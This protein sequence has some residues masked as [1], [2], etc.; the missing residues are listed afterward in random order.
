MTDSPARPAP[1]YGAIAQIAVCSVIWGT[2]WYAITLQ[3]GTVD[4]LVSVTYRFALAAAALFA[5]CVL[6]RLPIRLTRAQHLAVALQGLL[7]FAVQYPLVYVAEETVPSAVVA[8]MF[9][10]LAFVN[11]ALFRLLFGQSAQRAAWAGALL[12]VIGVAALF[13]GELRRT[14]FDAAALGGLATAAAAVVV[15]AGGNLAAFKAQEKGAPVVASTAWAM[16]YGAAAVA[17]FATASGVE[18]RFEATA[19][20]VVSLLY[21]SLFGSTL[22]FGLYFALARARG[23]ALASYISALTPPVAM[24]VSVLLEG[25]RFGLEA[26]LGLALVLAGQ[27]LMI[28][29]ARSRPAA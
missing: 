10:A 19:R 13:V 16:A 3:F 1:P 26:Y 11:L 25:A 18:W 8:V 22:A 28:R 7:V 27:G 29:A 6:R 15:S 12:G 9:A 17:I 20:Y 5:W 14:S 2:T 24:A 4:P 21:L 23:Y